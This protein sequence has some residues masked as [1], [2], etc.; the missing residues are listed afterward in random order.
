[1]RILLSTLALAALLAPAVPAAG[2]QGSR[3]ALVVQGASGE[4]QYATLHRGWLDELVAAL[5]DRFKFDP[6]NVSIL[7][8]KEAAGE[9]RATAENVRAV[10]GRLAR[11]IKAGDL[12]FV[13]LIGHGGG[14]GADAK[15]NLVGPDLT[16]AEWNELLKPI[17]GRV[18][19]VDTTS[20]SFGFLQGLA[21]PER[22]VITATSNHAQRFHTVFPDAFIKALTAEAADVDKNSRISLLEAFTYASRL[23]AQVY[24]Q[25]NRLATE[26][27]VF[28]D[29][30]DGKGREATATGPDGVVA[31][32]TYL[33]VP[34]AATSS[35]PEVQQMLVRQQE[36]TRQVDDLRIRRPSMKPADFDREFETLIIEL[37][38][39]SREVRRRGK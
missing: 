18:A 9:S 32:L 11:E 6:K 14:Q 22:I 35:N 36:L 7:A 20:S 30:G 28:D 38:L 3:Y 33:D 25:S 8:E 27:A 10:L 15:F 1:M 16:I 19:V 37:A 2:Q 5:R 17:A 13:V 29:N 26:R 39:V 12:L 24:E 4:E 34:E 31:G 21:G 23:V